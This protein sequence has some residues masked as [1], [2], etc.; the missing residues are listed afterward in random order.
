MFEDKMRC[1]KS[2]IKICKKAAD[3]MEGVPDLKDLR[4]DLYM[5]SLDFQGDELEGLHEIRS[6]LREC[7][8]TWEDKAFYKSASKDLIYI[9]YRGIVELDWIEIHMSFERNE[10]SEKLLGDCKI[11]EET[12][13][14][15]PT[16]TYN[17]VCLRKG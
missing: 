9:S 15:E 4:Y 1:Y 5:L 11:I 17:V 6:L 12:K 13:T 2:A 16:T 8:A 10:E 14:P 3:L 7:F